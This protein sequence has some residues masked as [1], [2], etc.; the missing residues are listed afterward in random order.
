MTD[1]PLRLLSIFLSLLGIAVAGYLTYVHYADIS[2]ICAG[3]GGGCEKVQA[4]DQ[5]KLAGVPV[6][7][8]GL[9]SYVTLL[10][11]NVARGEIARVGAALVA[12]VGFGF[13]MYLTYQSVEVI[14]ATCQWCL[15][16]ATV[17]T[18]MAIVCV[19]RLL[20]GD[21]AVPVRA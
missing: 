13:S 16:S 18:C 15:G 4:S 6:A 10:V 14:G 12:I 9:L 11:L 5:S 21:A 8:L 3:S 19:W 7:L 1:R 2:P 17:M 20:R